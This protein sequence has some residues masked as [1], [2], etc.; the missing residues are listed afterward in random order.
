MARKFL[1]LTALFAVTLFSC[2]ENDETSIITIDSVL[3]Q[4]IENE[5]GEFT[6]DISSNAAYEVS[7]TDN[8]K[9]LTVIEPVTRA[10]ESSKI[11][12]KADPN[13]DASSREAIVIVKDSKS[14]TSTRFKIIQ[15]PA[16]PTLILVDENGK[17]LEELV[18]TVEV[19][20]G[21]IQ[22]YVNANVPFDVATDPTI[23]W[24]KSTKSQDNKSVTL[25]ITSHTAE[26]TK[27]VARSGTV[28]F[29]S[30][31]GKVSA[32]FIVTQNARKAGIY[33]VTEVGQLEALVLEL[34][35]ESTIKTLKN[36]TISGPLNDDDI[37]AINSL[38]RELSV[39]NLKDAQFEKVP[40]EAFYRQD[41]SAKTLTSITLPE[42]VT[43]IEERAFNGS[44]FLSEVKLPSTLIKI[45]NYAF[46]SCDSLRSITIPR[47]VEVIGNYTFAYSQ[48]LEHVIFEE[49]SQLDTIKTYAFNYTNLGGEFVIPNSVRFIGDWAFSQSFR[50][51]KRPA[52]VKFGNNIES[53]G[54]SIFRNN[55]YL[56]AVNIP[57]FT[58]KAIPN[59][60]FYSTSLTTV[61]IGEGIETIGTQAFFAAPTNPTIT[62]VTF[63]ATLKSIGANAFQNQSLLLEA[64]IPVGTTYNA[65]NSF[66]TN[67]VVTTFEPKLDSE[68]GF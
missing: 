19:E 9:W 30:G 50:D 63:P 65:T 41:A 37:K 15:N 26:H 44:F 20:G 56:I 27:Y 3:T 59:T 64:S 4:Y 51:E 43:E 47:S 42:G 40:F 11:K 16:N 6:I 14:D 25:E 39:L 55:S 13:T 2:E 29:A 67:T 17:P 54:T 31:D 53:I 34:E 46:N 62:S 52:S 12:L 35:D 10:V 7:I 23:E 66:H 21:K 22:V 68:L 24:I 32:K 48:Q 8:P 1:L 57:D 60:A 36:V 61:V 33:T 5:G 49:E 38:F 18:A 58:I 45:G 28:Y